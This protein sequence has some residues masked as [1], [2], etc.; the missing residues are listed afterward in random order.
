[1]S[2]VARDTVLVLTQAQD[3]FVPERVVAE[4]EALGGRALRVD[5]GGYPLQ[6]AMALELGADG[7]IGGTVLGVSLA[8]IAGVYWRRPGLAEVSSL[9]QEAQAAVRGEAALDWAALRD[10]LEDA[11]ANVVNPGAAADRFEGHKLRQLHLAQRSG[12]AIPDTLVGNDPDAVRAFAA[13][14]DQDLICKLLGKVSWGFEQGTRMPTTRLG[15]EELANLDGLGAS[16]LCFQP[17]LAS[18]AEHRVTWID[19]EVFVGEMAGGEE[20]DWREGHR[21]GWRHGELDGDTAAALHRFMEA[22]GLRTGAIDLLLPADGGAPVFLEV[23]PDGEWGHLE[24]FLGLPVAAA[25]A[26]ALLRGTGLE[27]PA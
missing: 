13:R 10:L 6:E 2:P 25:L 5:T 8:R 7:Q 3:H 1:M 24:H 21:G 18:R 9:P 17:R 26:R 11:G 23:N 16:P 15:P 22:T 4:V 19:G 20:P 14:H 12:L 27:A